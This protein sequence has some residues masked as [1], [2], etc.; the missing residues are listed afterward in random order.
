M[1]SIRTA[2][3]VILCGSLVLLGCGKDLP[4]LPDPV[5][6]EGFVHLGWDAYAD[7]DFVT[8]MEYFQQA[9]E[10]DVDYAPGFL[11][12]G[13]T[14]ISMDDYWNV[15]GDYFYMAAQL[16]GGTC[17]LVEVAE[18]QMQDTNWTVFQCVD[19]V[20]TAYDMQVITSLGDSMYFDSLATTY[21]V[22]PVL[23]GKYLYGSSPFN[24][25][26][27]PRYGDIPFEYRF[28]PTADN[29]MAMFSLE[30]GFTNILEY[31]DS[32]T[33]DVESG[34]T[35]V[36]INVPY[37]AVTITGDVYRTWISAD[38][39]LAYDYVTYAASGGA[40]QI[41]WDALAGWALLEE[42]RAENGNAVL[43]N[44]A[45]WGLYTSV[46]TY[47][48]GSGLYWAGIETFSETQLKGAAASAAFLGQAFRFAWFSCTDMGY[49]LGL[50]PESSAFVFEL[51]QVIESM[52]TAP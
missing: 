34:E 30:N 48:F 13:W 6:P 1:K 51:M 49:G 43:A 26:A 44:A 17:P 39:V 7:N 20:L 40:G 47:D 28:Q 5:Y 16:D 11:G 41:T 29:C 36:Y 33:V 2:L 46:A 8:A 10:S 35:W 21:F 22:D 18:T 31:V 3:L 25:T 15:A 9:I 14:A 42:V 27:F 19:P 23:I 52:L 37:T 32:I 45:I 50:D 24:T 4:T 12:A 38:N